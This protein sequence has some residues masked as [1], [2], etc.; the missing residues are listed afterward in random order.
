MSWLRR[1]PRAPP[2]DRQPDWPRAEDQVAQDQQASGDAADGAL[3]Q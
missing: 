2:F 3:D 1:H